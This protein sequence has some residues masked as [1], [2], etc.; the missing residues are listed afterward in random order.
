MNKEVKTKITF[1]AAYE[2]Y[3]YEDFQ[4]FMVS[5][6]NRVFLFFFFFLGSSG[7]GVI[8]ALEIQWK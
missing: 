5:V 6:T 4:G 3:G 2:S 1:S 7:E 8:S